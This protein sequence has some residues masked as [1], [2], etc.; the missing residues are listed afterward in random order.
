MPPKKLS[1]T[2]FVPSPHSRVAKMRNQSA[3]PDIQLANLFY[4]SETAYFY[5]SIPMPPAIP[6]PGPTSFF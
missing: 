1:S 4:L 3:D 2:S 5:N 6:G